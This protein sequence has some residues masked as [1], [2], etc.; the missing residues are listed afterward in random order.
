MGGGA[1][2]LGEDLGRRTEPGLGWPIAW[3][4]T[5]LANTEHQSRVDP[6]AE[7]GRVTAHPGQN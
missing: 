7:I 3:M 1:G 6:C 5:G 4:D 2:R